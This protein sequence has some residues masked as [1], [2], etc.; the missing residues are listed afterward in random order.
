MVLA[1]PFSPRAESEPP[2]M[3]SDSTADFLDL[4]GGPTDPRYRTPTPPAGIPATATPAPRP[5][6]ITLPAQR[7]ERVMIGFAIAMFLRVMCEVYARARASVRAEPVTAPVVP[8]VAALPPAPVAVPVVEAPA[9]AAPEVFF[10]AL[11]DGRLAL[12]AP[13]IRG[14]DG[15]TARPALKAATGATFTRDGRGGLAAVGL[16]EAWIMPASGLTAARAW[17][18]EWFAVDG[19]AVQE[20]SGV[21]LAPATAPT[22]SAS[23]RQAVPTVTAEPTRAVEAAP[24]NTAPSPEFTERLNAARARRAAAPAPVT[25][26]AAMAGLDAAL[27][28]GTSLTVAPDDARV[29][30]A[31]LT[32]G[33]LIAGARAEQQGS[34]MGWTGRKEANRATLCAAL[35][36][37]GAPSDWAPKS[38]SAHAHAGA[39]IGRLSRDGLIPRTAR[40]ADAISQGDRRRGVSGRWIVV[41]ANLQGQVGDAAGSIVLTAELINDRLVLTGD[42]VLAAEVRADYERLAGG[43]VY[44]A[45]DVT[46]WLGG[47]LRTKLGAVRMAQAWYV[48][49][50]NV[51]LGAAICE[52]IAATGWGTDWMLPALPVAT[53]AQLR[54]GLARGLTTE[55]RDVLDDLANQRAA[56]KEAKRTDI[57]ERAAATLLKR[58]QEVNDRAA[59][60]ALILGPEYTADVR[61]TIKAALDTVRPLCS[62]FAQRGAMLEMD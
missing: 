25:S 1:R 34:L 30:A 29:V 61:R 53:S 33:T 59:Q 40:G 26:A 50:G 52:A 62:D 9:A 41:N 21:A 18:Q 36:T 43:D 3:D 15:Y 7:A 38:K 14:A 24:V 48:P 20:T 28:G 55:A 60:Y 12:V 10:R 39:A 51:A 19:G 22:P 32:D 31:A 8:T 54:Q 23:T 13:F 44:A 27:G 45:A 5:G 11:P 57:G 42:P 58:L 6:E 4:D 49:S 16:T 46:G 17:C 56:A 37:A 2:M 47:V 35:A